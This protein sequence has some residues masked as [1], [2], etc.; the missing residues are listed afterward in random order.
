MSLF[1]GIRTYFTNKRLKKLEKDILALRDKLHFDPRF[2]PIDVSKSAAEHF[3]CRIAEYKVWS[4]GNGA[5]IRRF[6][7]AGGA[8]EER[9]NSCNY[10]WRKAPATTRMIHSGVPGLISTRMADIL[11][12]NGVTP[13]VTAYKDGNGDSLDES[14]EKSKKANA[15]T[16][17]L[18]KR[19]G[20]QD[21]LHRSATNESWGGHCFLKLSHDVDSSHFPILE[22]YDITQAEVIKDR[23]IT[24]AIVF[25]RWYEN[26]GKTYRLDEVYSTTE[27][28]D[29]CI[30]YHLYKWEGDKCIEV[31][32]LSIPQTA[33]LFRVGESG[34]EKGIPLDEN[35]TYIYKGLK[36]MLAFEKPNRTPSL[37]FPESN[38][39]ASD[40]EGAVD[41]FD[42]LDEVLSGN[43]GEVRTNKTKRY[44]PLTLIPRDEN[45]KALPFDEFADCYVNIEGDADQ[46]AKN[47]IITSKVDDKTAS[48]MEK[49]KALLSEICNKAK[50]SPFALGITW[51]EA[52]NPSAESQ[53]ERNKI[54]LDMRNGKLKLWKPL[55]EE[56]ILRILQ[57]NSW[58]RAHN[59]LPDDGLPDLDI[60]WENA[61]V[62]VEF[63]EY[64][65]PSLEA[66]LTMYGAAKAARVVSTEECVKQLH[67]D[68]TVKM[69]AEE[70]NRIRFEE[71][72]SAD[73][74]M[75]L[76]DL[77]GGGEE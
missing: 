27:D 17:E 25:K 20:L 22:A 39:G 6:Y 44:V 14:K 66:R 46:N 34:A 9:F 59:D 7:N 64:L 65:E 36:G 26:K 77:T 61:S 75:S 60:T 38:Y 76:P 47:E 1:G 45:G 52:V 30:S 51:L 10:F 40:Y 8:G 28:G 42:A 21:A 24:K 63:G 67:P 33:A 43:V 55:I 35:N 3:S 73:N 5:L 70:V 18:L 29:A 4:M 56:L 31:D 41:L 23:G 11:F 16:G 58:I 53:Q 69:V 54:T 19:V 62:Q 57:L 50:I 37:E 49:W 2:M 48:F 12:K 68:W 32:L 15:L 74:P 71:G 13:N 72:M